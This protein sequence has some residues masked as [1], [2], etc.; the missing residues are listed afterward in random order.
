M[1]LGIG[2]G[3]EYE[4][5]TIFYGNKYGNF[6]S[7]W[8]STLVQ[9][10]IFGMVPYLLYTFQKLGE[11]RKFL[12]FF[13]MILWSNI[14]YQFNADAWYWILLSLLGFSEAFER[15]ENGKNRI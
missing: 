1:F 8:L 14:F 11:Y 2:W 6:H 4:F 7:G 13:V 10:G 3:T 12:P 5:T 9:V 15:A